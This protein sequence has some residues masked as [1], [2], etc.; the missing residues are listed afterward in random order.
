MT[1]EVHRIDEIHYGIPSSEPLR[2]VV[3][4]YVVRGSE[5]SYYFPMQH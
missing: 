1:E 2:L 4:W 3:H 5:N